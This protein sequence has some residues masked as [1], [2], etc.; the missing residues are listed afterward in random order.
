MT[1]KYKNKILFFI[2]LILFIL[3]ITFYIH[4]LNIISTIKLPNF[5][6]AILNQYGHWTINKI[7]LCYI[8][9]SEKVITTMEILSGGKI[10]T[11]MKDLG[12]EQ[13]NHV[14]FTITLVNPE[15]EEEIERIIIEKNETIYIFKEQ[16]KHKYQIAASDSNNENCNSIVLNLTDVEP[17]ITLSNLIEDTKQL[18]GEKFFIYNCSDNNCQ[19]L[20]KNV[21][22]LLKSKDI[23]FESQV[24]ENI[25]E[26]KIFQPS[27]E[28]MKHYPTT[29]KIAKL[30]TD[31]LRII[32]FF[33]ES[34]L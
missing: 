7:E 33:K 26:Y 25:N 11:H 27:E 6:V 23:K 3:V 32:T 5:S 2:L 17:K 16:D 18:M 4:Y 8:P 30:L 20:A 34:S 31:T 13:P 24:E 22:H 21:L 10:I 15:N 19:F 14:Y 1:S 9:V 28:L 29:E 12:Y